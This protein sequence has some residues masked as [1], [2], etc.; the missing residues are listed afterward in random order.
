MRDDA[1]PDI[2]LYVRVPNSTSAQ[3]D[4]FVADMTADASANRSVALADLSYL[5]SYADQ[6]RFAERIL[7]SGLAAR[8][9]AY[10]S[11]NTNANTVGTALAEAI[12]ADAGRRMRT[13]DSLAHRTFTFTLF[14]DDYAFHDEVRPDLNATLAAQGI[15]DH[16]LLAP[17]V[18]AIIAQR[19]RALLWNYA[20]QILAQLD[21]GYHIAALSIELPWSRTFETS[22]DVGLA[23]NL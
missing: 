11:W 4:A 17:D 1:R 20:E 23:P 12:A 22:I 18:A 2:S 7:A 3:D 19:D 16:S 9:D 6:A 8:L 10:S 15:T 5:R 14:L 21:P 13:Y